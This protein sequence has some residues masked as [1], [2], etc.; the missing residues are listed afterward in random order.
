MRNVNNQENPD[1]L[2][3]GSRKLTK[4]Q[5]RKSELHIRTKHMD[6]VSHYPLITAFQ[7]LVKLVL[8]DIAEV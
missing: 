7:Y 5:S 8:N 6:E 2:I 3:V 4:E 1:I